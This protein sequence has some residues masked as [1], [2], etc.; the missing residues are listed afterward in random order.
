M[1]DSVYWP[2]SGRGPGVKPWT[3]WSMDYYLTNWA[4][5]TRFIH[6]FSYMYNIL[7]STNR[8]PWVQT[9]CTSPEQKD[10]LLCF[11]IFM[12]VVK[13]DRTLKLVS[14]SLFRSVSIMVF[15]SNSWQW[16]ITYG[17]PAE[18]LWSHHTDTVTSDHCCG[19]SDTT[20]DSVILVQL[21]FD[22]I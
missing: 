14:G 16:N 1:K 11:S 6:L 5:A 15:C 19:S 8:I 10:S 21:Q 13:S 17:L 3:L 9:C 12:S 7:F 2:L 22:E 4:T 18:L 20:A